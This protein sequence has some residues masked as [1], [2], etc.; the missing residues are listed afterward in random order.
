MGYFY[1]LFIS[2]ISLLIVFTKFIGLY[3]AEFY[4]MLKVSLSWEFV[5]VDLKVIMQIVSYMVLKTMLVAQK[6]IMF[7]PFLDLNYT[8]DLIN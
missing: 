8:S 2:Y 6:M 3:Y 5:G 1:L 4:Y 7:L